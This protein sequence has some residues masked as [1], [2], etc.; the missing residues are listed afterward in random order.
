MANFNQFNAILRDAVDT[1]QMRVNT[2][3]ASF[4]TDFTEV[5]LL[6]YEQKRR[7][8]Q[9]A[10]IFHGILLGTLVVT[11]ALG[12]FAGGPLNG[13]GSSAMIPIGS[14]KLLAANPVVLGSGVAGGAYAG[15]SA[16]AQDFQKSM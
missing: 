4:A 13:L 10:L 6:K 14:G 11:S 8:K 5:G 2:W 15:G 9:K 16:I 7:E 1:A 3:A 12:T